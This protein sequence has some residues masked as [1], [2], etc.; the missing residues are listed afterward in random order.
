MDNGHQNV[1]AVKFNIVKKLNIVECVMSQ[2]QFENYLK[3]LLIK[4]T[5]LIFSSKIESIIISKFLEPSAF[6][7]SS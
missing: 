1:M 7:K 5:L 6:S 4:G 2:T 3:T